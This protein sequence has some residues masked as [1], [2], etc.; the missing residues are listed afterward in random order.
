MHYNPGVQPVISVVIPMLDAANQVSYLL[1]SLLRQDFSEPWELIAVDN[2]SGDG[3]AEVARGLLDVDPPSNLIRHDVVV[4]PS[5]RGYATPRNAGAR[6]A[7]AP[8]L[9]FCDADG[10]VDEL[11]LRSMVR[12][13]EQHP[14][15]ASHKFRTYDVSSRTPDSV[16]FDQRELY[17]FYG[18]TY[19]ATAGLGCRR[20]VFDALG[21]F[22]THF[23]Q[24]GEDVDFSL[25]ARF[26]LGVVPVMSQDALYWT[27]VPRRLTKAYSRGIR[28]G[29]S[30]VRLHRRHA[31]HLSDLHLERTPPRQMV[32]RLGRRVYRLPRLSRWK[33]TSFVQTIGTRVGKTI[34]SIKREP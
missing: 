27:T 2:G 29:R 18:Q 16:L 21:G 13:L 8:L 28:N 3:T 4:V 30:Q 10:V 26:R 11:W 14:L 7:T 24:G 32:Y 6:V 34:W 5:P 31:D 20:E 33:V 23:D 17:G 9:A 12:A 22:D 25:R 19:A 1:T 15:V